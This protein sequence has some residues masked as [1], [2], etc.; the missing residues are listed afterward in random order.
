MKIPNGTWLFN[1][2][3]NLTDY[4]ILE[5]GKMENLASQYK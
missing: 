5:A 4:P 3:D 2:T 1:I